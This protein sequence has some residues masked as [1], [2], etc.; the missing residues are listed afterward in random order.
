MDWEQ[1]RSVVRDFSDEMGF[2]FF[3]I[4]THQDLREQQPGAVDLRDYAE[5][6]VRRIIGEC[7]F[8]RDPVMRACIFADSAFLWSELRNI[9]ALDGK[10]RLALELG[11]REGLNEG[12]TVPCGK[13]GHHLGSC[14][15]AGLRAAKRGKLLIG[16]ADVRRFHIPARSHSCRPNDPCRADAAP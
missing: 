15:F 6:A 2:R 7:G 10:D 3:A 1:L 9:I 5:G 8:R 13:L 12:I 4:V 14:T 16:P 11:R